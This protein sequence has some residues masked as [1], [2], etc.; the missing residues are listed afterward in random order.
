VIVSDK[1]RIAEYVSRKIDHYYWGNF[2]ALGI[3][4]DGQ[5]VAGVLFNDYKKN[6]KCSIHCAGEGKRWLNRTFL[7]MVFEYAFN[8]LG[9][10][11]IINYVCS[12]NK[13]SLRF[14]EHIGFKQHGSPIKDATENG[15]LVLFT[16]YKQDCKWIQQTP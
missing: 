14:T 12:T 1:E 6:V 4:K 11:V 16:Y 5:I 7:R 9:C 2:T 10:R 3:E 13:D 15:D 8:Q